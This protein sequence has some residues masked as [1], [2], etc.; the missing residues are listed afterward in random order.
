MKRPSDGFDGDSDTLEN[1]GP[2]A[3][4]F[5]GTSEFIISRGEGGGIPGSIK[6]WDLIF[7]IVG[8]LILALYTIPIKIIQTAQTAVT[9][10]IESVG[11][12]LVDLIESLFESPVETIGRSVGGLEGFITDLGV[13]GLPATIAIGLGVSWTLWKVMA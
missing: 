1:D 10:A 11:N 12:W 13:L 4:L 8:S 3:G 2:F 6:I 7:A 5:E 9:G